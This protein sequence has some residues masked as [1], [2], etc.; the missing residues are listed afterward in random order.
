[1]SC[2]GTS[3]VL[4]VV[5]LLLGAGACGEGERASGNPSPAGGAAEP[6]TTVDPSTGPVPSTEASTDTTA[7]DVTGPRAGGTSGCGTTPTG[8]DDHNVVSRRIPSA[9]GERDFLVYVPD[10]YDPD[11]PT[12]VVVTFHGAGS[13]KEQQLAYS[14]FG[15]LA[16]RDGWLV[17]APDALG[18]PRRWSPFGIGGMA[19]I[20][21]IRDL[22]FF[23]DTLDTVGD[24]LCVD[25]SRI[26]VAGMSSGGY[27]SAAVACELGDRVAAAGPVTATIYAER[28]CSGAPPMPYA[29]FHGTDDPVVPFLGPVPGP[30]GEPGPGSAE[31]SSQAW[32]EHNGCDAEPTDERIGTQVVHRSWSGCDAPTH[33]YIVEGGGH[34]WPGSVVD[35]PQ[36]GATTP[37][38]S[39]TEVLW[40]LFSVS[41]R[42]TS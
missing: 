30:G 8:V 6:A 28:A 23:E 14:G 35:L 2:S 39:A 17:V 36:F 5:L 41:R 32:A 40:E 18:E 37:D 10:S 29:Y 7:P 38:I 33:L 16:D 12:P 24:E 27:M 21:G 4:V 9:G 26:Y 34:T 42:P 31:F 19:G 20:E 22:D 15:P 25:P 13:N 1:M 11:V 3:R